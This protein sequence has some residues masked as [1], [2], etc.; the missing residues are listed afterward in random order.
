MCKETAHTG[1]FG[2]I[3]THM[4]KYIHDMLSRNVD[5][6]AMFLQQ[7]NSKF[8]YLNSLYEKT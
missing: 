1:D 3:C 2:T 5:F 6:K 7:L 8:I 4:N